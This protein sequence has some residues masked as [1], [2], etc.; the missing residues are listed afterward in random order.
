MKIQI[1]TLDG[2]FAVCRMNP[3]NSVATDLWKS[4]FLSIT[5]TADE[6]SIVCEQSLVPDGSKVEKDWNAFKVVGP[7]DFSLTGI[8][9]ALTN[10]LA[11]A[12]ISLFATST[13]DT[14]YVLI[15]SKD[16]REALKVLEMSGVEIL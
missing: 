12:G 4:R 10:P 7:L 16:F 8:L 14:D 5:K 2:T 3:R 15:K 11:S 6:L 1:E 9:A 13:F